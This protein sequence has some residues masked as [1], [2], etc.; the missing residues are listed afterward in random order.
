MNLNGSLLTLSIPYHYQQVPD[1]DSTFN[2]NLIPVGQ[3]GFWVAE[4]IGERGARKRV[5]AFVSPCHRRHGIC[6]E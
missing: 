3:S 6:V 5:R 4:M 1:P 2:I